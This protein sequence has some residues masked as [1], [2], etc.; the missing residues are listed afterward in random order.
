MMGFPCAQFFNGGIEVRRILL[1]NQTPGS[2]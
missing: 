1:G 2:R